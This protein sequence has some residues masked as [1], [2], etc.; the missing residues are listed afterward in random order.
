[1]NRILSGLLAPLALLASQPGISTNSQRARVQEAFGKLPLSFES[2]RGQSD[3]SVRFLS[4]GQGYGLFLTAD[5]AVLKLK[6]GPVLRM[7]MEGAS[8][9]A[10]TTGLERLPGQANYFQGNDPAKWRTGVDT[11]AKVQY[12]GVY[13]G[14]DL[15][16]Y[17]NQGQLE[18]DF[19]VAP[20]ADPNRIGLS[21]EGSAPTVE[22]NGNLRLNEAVQFHK[23][24]VYQL[25]NGAKRNIA[26][27][28]V[29]AGNRVRFA[30]GAYD[31]T[32]T[33]V[34]DPLLVYSTYVGGTSWDQGQG[35]AVDSKGDVYITG[36]T[37][38]SD[39]PTFHA[40][41]STFNSMARNEAFVTKLSATGSAVIY[42]TY[43][44]GSGGVDQ[45]YD[46]AV[47]SSSNAY[48]VGTT[49]SNDFPVTAG[50]FQTLCGAGDVN[51]NRVPGC[52]G[53]QTS[54]FVTKINSAGSALVYST[55]LG[56]NNASYGSGI[57]VDAAG[58]AYV[59]GST[60]SGG[61]TQ[62]GG[63]AWEC[64]P[65]TAGA[66]MPGSVN[67]AQGEYAAFTKFNAAGSSLVY[68][69]IYGA[70]DCSV[71][72]GQTVG[73]GIAIDTAGKAYITGYTQS[74]VMLVTAGAFQ[75]T[76][77]PLT[78]DSHYLN[79]NRAFVARLDPSKSGLA[80]LLYGTY[81][82]GTTA[83]SQ[84]RGMGIVADATGAAY[85]T[86]NAVSLDFPVTAG[87]FQT[88]C[89]GTSFCNAGFVTK[90]NS[91]GSALAYSTFLGGLT[92]GNYAFAERIRLD[93][94]KNAY[95]AGYESAVFPVVNP[96]QASTGQDSFISVLNTTGS[97]LTFSS[98]VG[99][100]GADVAYSLALDRTNNVYITGQTS[101]TDIGT[102]GAFET[103]FN[104]YYDAFVTK[105]AVAAADLA[106]TNSAPSTV[107]SG[108]D[109]TYVITVMNNGPD[110]AAGVSIGDTLPT[111]TTFVSATT[112]AG[113]CTTPAVGG[114]GRVT[115]KNFSLLN[116]SSVSVDITIKV[117][118]A[119]G[120]TVKD[121]ASGST[122]VFDPVSTNNSAIAST[123][124]Q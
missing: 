28:Y 51:G 116:G 74:P 112:T 104:G 108:A 52:G 30:L 6:S 120:K 60:Y 37:A 58:E 67:F 78:S 38:S 83:G 49:N 75:T 45:G 107:T 80:S 41:Q 4:R 42:S 119:A 40:F 22:P 65:T 69:T 1:M 13:P 106:V 23:P 101:S 35:I 102:A 79:G 62:V 20:G 57:A 87:A 85:V 72:C 12:R 86:G 122:T 124:V 21:F 5:S 31:H 56:G 123:L 96:I 89:G 15:V 39:F 2:N 100:N 47:D 93:S 14:V 113:T 33:L 11:F 50:A 97:A 59:S 95:V 55:F 92:A 98:Y 9:S 43:L 90:L 44:G 110:T 10:S 34:I 103:T 115:C 29:V 68:S 81:L 48:V 114:T 70:T 61:C 24:V 118:L 76:A 66:V 109:L 18:Y 27:G 88:T 36:W 82:G 117:N 3:P 25:V 63:V 77:T 91:T 53:N 111:G 121:T 105:V 26:G 17:G 71:T 8:G 46:I 54:M 19:V 16:Y 94:A 84:D 64:Y 73:N 99:G 32:R 7:K